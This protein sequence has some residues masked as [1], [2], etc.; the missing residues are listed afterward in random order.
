MATEEEPEAPETY[1]TVQE[2]LAQRLRIAA[3]VLGYAPVPQSHADASG[4][5]EA[6]I[7]YVQRPAA[8]SQ[9]SCSERR[10]QD[11]LEFR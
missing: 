2:I 5:V 10:K 9:R 7:G 6:R 1:G 3:A 11:T 4:W 8:A